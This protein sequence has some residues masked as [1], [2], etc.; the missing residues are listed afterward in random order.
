M[1]PRVDSVRS[2]EV[3]PARADVVIVGGGI[4]G[5]S[6]ALFLAQRRIPTLLCEKGLIA[7]EQSSRN[8]GWCRKMG[9]DP[10]EIQLILESMRLWRGM[11]A[12]L[13]AETGF[14]EAGIIRLTDQHADVEEW[15]AWLACARDYQ[16][17]TR[18][19]TAS[20][21]DEVVSASPRRWRAA[22]VTPSDG[23]AEPRLATPA[24]ANAARRLGATVLTACA[25]RGI[26]T[27]AG[28]VAAAITEKGRVV[29][30]SIVLA[31]GAWSRLFCRSL[32]LELP[33][34]KVMT[35]V[36]RTAKLEGG[37]EYS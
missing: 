19:V 9:R 22:M 30:D 16:I 15:Q 24:I 35:S 10:R 4:I 20:E 32:G 33:Q 8:W 7:G 28:R 3:L 26:E 13:G 23:R 5:T 34:L 31:G 21:L 6:T 17:D 18:I 2:D 37:P 25:V 36:L 27:K 29:C 12:M 1:A 14:R 11:N